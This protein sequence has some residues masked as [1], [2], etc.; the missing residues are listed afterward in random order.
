MFQDW[1]VFY[2]TLS[3]IALGRG[4]EV[5]R[6]RIEP[7]GSCLKLFVSRV[8]ISAPYARRLSYHCHTICFQNSVMYKSDVAIYRL[9]TVTLPV[10]RFD[11]VTVVLIVQ[12]PSNGIFFTK[13]R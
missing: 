12:V 11:R 9:F 4:H 6:V 2:L 13:S 8:E 3:G 7:R 1:H 10:P 5:G